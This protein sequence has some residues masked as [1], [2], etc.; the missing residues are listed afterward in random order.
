[1]RHEVLCSAQL[2]QEANVVKNS[3]VEP[4]LPLLYSN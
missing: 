4:E 2:S 3:L 1:L